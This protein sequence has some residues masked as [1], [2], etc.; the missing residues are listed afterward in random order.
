MRGRPR[1]SPGVARRTILV[2]TARESSSHRGCSGYR[3]AMASKVEWE[4]EAKKR[5]EK[6]PFFI[7][8]LVR[9]RA[10]K[11]A[12]E[13]GLSRVTTALLDELKASEH[14]GTPSR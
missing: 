13:R 8:P 3:R 12:D 6:V 2:S 11:A 7:R 4:P 10:E 9:R 1:A 5:L 14:R